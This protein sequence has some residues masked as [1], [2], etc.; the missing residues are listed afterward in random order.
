MKKLFP[1]LTVVLAL[2]VSPLIAQDGNNSAPK[3]DTPAAE[4]ATEDPAEE[5]EAVEAPATLDSG[6]TAWMIVAT[7]IV[8]LM[9]IPG[10]VQCHKFYP[11]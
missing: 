9:T 11:M 7:A 10:L 6:D 4:V 2:F 5:E 8:L 1:I 3:E